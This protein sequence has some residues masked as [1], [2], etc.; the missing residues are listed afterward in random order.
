MPYILTSGSGSFNHNSINNFKIYTTQNTKYEYK[1]VDGT[2]Y[3]YIM[4]IVLF[5]WLFCAIYS[6][7]KNDKN[8]NNSRPRYDSEPSSYDSDD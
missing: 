1:T 5:A 2:V 3:Y 8:I 4:F 7:C 6:V